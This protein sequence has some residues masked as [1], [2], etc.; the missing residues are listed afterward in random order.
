MMEVTARWPDARIGGT[1]PVL[2]DRIPRVILQAVAHALHDLDAA[3]GASG[4]R[5]CPPVAARVE[6]G[7]SGS[8][9]E[10]MREVASAMSARARA[11]EVIAH[12]LANLNTE[13]FRRARVSFARAL[14]GASGLIEP[15]AGQDSGGGGAAGSGGP[16][17]GGAAPELTMHARLD[18]APAPPV[19]TGKSSDVAIRGAGFLVVETE[20]GPRY[21]RDGAL[22]INERGE[23]AHR[24]GHAIAGSGGPIAVA[25]G[26][27]SITARGEVMV[28]GVEVGRLQV[29][30]FESGAVLTPAASGLLASEDT[31]SAVAS[32]ELVPGHTEGSNVDPVSE[33]VTMLN[34]FKLYEAAA[35]A[36]RTHDESLAQLLSTTRG[37]L[38]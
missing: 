19:F 38:R 23:L 5:L 6:I 29:V 36:L 16:G 21:T 13:G 27:F 22:M 4:E 20:E 12:N 24:S 11:Q 33:M 3:R 1:R 7:E 28:D 8:M 31:P 37:T 14:A 10:S 17:G 2:R 25:S 26:N 34:S 15:P 18:L 35:E 30:R 9:L 32:P